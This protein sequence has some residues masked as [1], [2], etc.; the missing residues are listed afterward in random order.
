MIMNRKFIRRT[1]PLF[2]AS[3]FAVCS[4]ARAQEKLSEAIRVPPAPPA[5]AAAP[6]AG[7]TSGSTASAPVRPQ[8]L[9][10][11]NVSD[12]QR[13]KLREA[14]EKLRAEQTPLYEK[15][16]AIRRELE[17]AAQADPLDE[18]LIREKAAALGVIEGD[19]ALL[20]AR[21]YQAIRGVL[22][23]R[24]LENFK[25]ATAGADTNASLRLRSPSPIERAR[26]LQPPAQN[27]LLPTPAPPAP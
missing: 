11:E 12:D 21:H 16:R 23:S 7:P 19:L 6:A 4:A 25:P 27:P 2:A 3:L 22:P 13:A 8:N 17:Q 14:S 15:L 24:P 1:A 9:P 5:R 10:A 20:R 26:A 18:K